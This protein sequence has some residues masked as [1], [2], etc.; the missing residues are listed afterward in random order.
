[1]IRRPRFAAFCALLFLGILRGSVHAGDT[2]S[3]PFRGARYLHRSTDNPKWDM[4]LLFLDLTDPAIRLTTTPP[5]ERRSTTS[6]FA[7][8][9]KVQLAINGDFCN[10]GKFVPWGLTIGEGKRWP[11]APDDNAER[12]VV[13]IGGNV[14]QLTPPEAV[15]KPEPWVRDAMGGQPLIVRDGALHD[16][17]AER[18]PRT[19]LGVSKDRKTLILL[20]V[21]GRQ[22]ELSVG[23][24]GH[25]MGR[26]FLEFGAWMAM[27]LDGGGSSTVW[28]E[29]KGV[30]NHPS[31]GSERT[32]MNH[33]GIYAAAGAS[34]PKGQ[35]RGLVKDKA[36]GQPLAQAKLEAGRDHLEL[37]AANGYYH[38]TQIPAGKATVVVTGQGYVKQVL[39]VPVKAGEASEMNVDL[40]PV[41]PPSG[42]APA[43]SSTSATA[44]GTPAPAAGGGAERLLS[45]ARTFRSGKL[46][47]KALEGYQDVLEK[48]PGTA[49]AAE[50]KAAVAGIEAGLP[51]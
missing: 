40:V 31:D 4:H 45:R 36:T 28:M 41:P 14:V 2:W 10:P 29:G 26:V 1:M 27:N 12:S 46:W 33:L 35:I 37:S 32:V 23:M 51:K 6:K 24:T 11:D 17:W 38:F 39:S 3:E 25:E 13:L 30:L 47:G 48:F 34:R 49:Q 50:A 44:T 8:R 22:K 18:H 20:V 16:D 15:V 5:E 19:A 21:D 9:K 7:N 43:S 42:P